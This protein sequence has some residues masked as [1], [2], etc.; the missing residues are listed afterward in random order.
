MKYLFT[1]FLCVIVSLLITV[2]ASQAFSSTRDLRGRSFVQWFLFELRRTEALKQC[3]E[4]MNRLWEIKA[5][6]IDDFIAD[7][8]TI[9]DVMERFAEAEELV[10]EGDV[11]VVASYRRPQT[12]E[13]VCRQLIGWVEDDLKDDPAKA[14]EVIQRLKRELD[15]EPAEAAIIR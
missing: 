7:R 10:E 14:R 12:K 2:G 8:A 5:A 4:M 3:A 11:G 1:L 13:Q 15:A 6:A 9:E